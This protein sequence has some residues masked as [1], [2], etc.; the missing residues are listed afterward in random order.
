[1]NIQQATKIV[2]NQ[3]TYA[4]QNMI[5]ALS[6]LIWLNTPEDTK[7]LEAAKIV[8]HDRREV[9]QLRRNLVLTEN[10]EPND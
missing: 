7:R 4:L 6:T 1:M 8:L 3:P 2:G 9:Q 10:F 5:K